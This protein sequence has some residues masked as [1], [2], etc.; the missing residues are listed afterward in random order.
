MAPKEL[1]T[2]HMPSRQTREY[3]L[4]AVAGILQLYMVASLAIVNSFSAPGELQDQAAAVYASPDNY[5]L[6]DALQSA[7]A[8]KQPRT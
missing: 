1:Q 7:L 6:L 4:V 8:G 2:S 3:P 5:T